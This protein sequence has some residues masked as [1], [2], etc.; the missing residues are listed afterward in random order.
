M[1]GELAFTIHNRHFGAQDRA[2]NFGPRQACYQA[3]FTLFIGQRVA[4]LG[5]AKELRDVVRC[6]HDSVFRAFFNHLARH[7][8]ANVSDLAFQVAHAGFARVVT[9]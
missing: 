2:T 5:D 7:F 8:A 4:E 9:G 1:S 3:D 6:E